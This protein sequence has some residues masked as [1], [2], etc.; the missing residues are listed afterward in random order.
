MD[1]G[2]D[3]TSFGADKRLAN[4]KALQQSMDCGVAQLDTPSMCSC[5]SSLRNFCLLTPLMFSCCRWAPRHHT[6]WK[7]V[8][9][10]CYK[11]VRFLSPWAWDQFSWY[12][13]LVQCTSLISCAAVFIW[14]VTAVV[15]E[16]T[17]IFPLID[18]IFSTATLKW[19]FKGLGFRVQ[20]WSFR[21]RSRVER[22][23]F[24]VNLEFRV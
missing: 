19:F 11:W 5:T 20:G 16:L 10:F 7:E 1:E 15:C 14:A 18:Q 2:W 17:R 13:S 4:N 6:S 12:A 24:R 8:W 23:G 22:L 21:F 3:G 9:L